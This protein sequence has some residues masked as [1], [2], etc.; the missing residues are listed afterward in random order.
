MNTLFLFFNAQKVLTTR[1]TLL[2]K[3]DDQDPSREGVDLGVIL[4]PF[5]TA[6][7]ATTVIPVQTPWLPCTSCIK[8]SRRILSCENCS[9]ARQQSIPFCNQSHGNSNFDGGPGCHVTARLTLWRRR[10]GGEV[11]GE[12]L[13]NSRRRNR[14]GPYTAAITRI[15]SQDNSSNSNTRRKVKYGACIGL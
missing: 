11:R 6:T 12:L 15:S 7:T 3:I 10:R 4:V 14:R 8:V 9:T 2:H 13:R 5:R 1:R